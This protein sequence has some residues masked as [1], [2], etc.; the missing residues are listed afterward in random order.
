[1][2]GGSP[3]EPEIARLAR[4]AWRRE[5]ASELGA[6]A[7]HSTAQHSVCA[8]KADN[9]CSCAPLGRFAVVVVAV[10]VVGGSIALIQP[11]QPVFSC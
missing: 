4:L 9:K 5:L 8:H 1:M 3:D 10:V 2:S 7:Q 6:R 11:E